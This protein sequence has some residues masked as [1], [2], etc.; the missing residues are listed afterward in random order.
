MIKCAG[1]RFGQLMMEMKH[2]T[3]NAIFTLDSTARSSLPGRVACFELHGSY[4]A[5]DPRCL[6][7]HCPV[8]AAQSSTVLPRS[9]V[10]FSASES[11]KHW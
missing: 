2:L 11:V 3:V 6:E 5:G 8:S 1:N 7:L 9:T 4:P 10:Y